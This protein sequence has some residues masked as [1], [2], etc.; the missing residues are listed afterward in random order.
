VIVSGEAEP[1]EKTV[2][3]INRHPA[4]LTDI[5]AKGFLADDVEDVLGEVAVRA[6]EQIDAFRHVNLP[7]W[8]RDRSR[9]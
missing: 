7:S 9:L 1:G 6:V 2:V 5:H 8:N 3:F 4:V